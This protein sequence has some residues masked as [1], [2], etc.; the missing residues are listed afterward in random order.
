MSR[1]PTLDGFGEPV[2]LQMQSICL[3]TA[4]GILALSTVNGSFRLVNGS[5]FDRIAALI[6]PQGD[7]KNMS[8]PS[9]NLVPAD[10]SDLPEFGVG[11]AT[12][13]EAQTG[14]TVFVSRENA[15]GS[16]CAVDVRGGGPATRETDLLKPEKMVQKANAVVLSGGSAFGLE[17]SCGVMEVLAQE[18]MGFVVGPVSVPIVPAAC[19]FDLLIGQ[20]VWPDKNMG[21]DAARSALAFQG[22][23]IE[24][25]SVGAGCGATVGK[26]GLPEQAMKSGFGWSGLRLGE[27]VVIACVVVNALGNITDEKGGWLA[28]TRAEDG[29]ILDPLVAAS[30]MQAALAETAAQGNK[31]AT[32]NTTAQ[33]DT[34]ATTNTTLGIVLTNA[35][36]DQAQAT[37][38]AQ[39]THDSYARAIC[40][41]HTQSDGDAIFVMA[42]G[43]TQAL[44]DMVSLLSNEAME[45]AIRSAVRHAE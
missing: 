14:C 1:D 13:A 9:I 26:L 30:A 18:G 33:P 45:H 23:D 39:S 11:H 32:T 31:A 41:V 22:S 37:K 16:V 10:F 15:E 6:M 38:V 29:T 25:G 40:P 7:E 8:S 4:F 44:P 35:A 34:N 3:K 20:P 5:S 21:A 17:A 24:Q 43:K 19:I 2:R 12:N 28:G 42:S 36:L 27:L